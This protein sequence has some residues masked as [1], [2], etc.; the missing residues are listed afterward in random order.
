[1]HGLEGEIRSLSFV[2]RSLNLNL[3]QDDSIPINPSLG[4]VIPEQSLSFFFFSIS[5]ATAV[6][7]CSPPAK[8]NLSLDLLIDSLLKSR[9]TTG[10][11]YRSPPSSR[12]GSSFCPCRSLSTSLYINA[13]I[14]PAWGFYKATS[15]TIFALGLASLQS[16]FHSQIEIIVDT[17]TAFRPL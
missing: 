5:A 6:C 13:A 9:A 8:D 12:A 14:T 11:P 2:G 1:M 3:N 15:Q 17:Y 4:R 10:F 16:S 7:G